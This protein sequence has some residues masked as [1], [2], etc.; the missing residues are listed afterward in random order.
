MR[1]SGGQGG[2]YDAGALHAQRRIFRTVSWEGV[3][4]ARTSLTAIPPPTHSARAVKR[5]QRKTA[6]C[7]LDNAPAMA[8]VRHRLGRCAI[9]TC[10]RERESAGPLASL[11]PPANAQLTHRKGGGFYGRNGMPG[12]GKAELRAWC[13]VKQGCAGWDCWRVFL[14][15]PFFHLS[16]WTFTKPM[17]EHPLFTDGAIIHLLLTPV[18]IGFYFLEVFVQVRG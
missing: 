6:L 5:G 15:P 2:G 11:P 7:L 14:I 13:E 10:A 16:R 12:P 8:V 18:T 9:A 3:C 1:D 17:V 4:E